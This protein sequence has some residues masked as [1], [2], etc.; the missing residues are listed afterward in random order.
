MTIIQTPAL[1]E[2]FE[3]VTSLLSKLLQINFTSGQR[4]GRSQLE[5]SVSSVIGMN[6]QGLIDMSELELMKLEMLTQRLATLEEHDKSLFSK[7]VRSLRTHRFDEYISTLCEVNTSC[8]LIKAKASFTKTEAPDFRIERRGSPIYLECTSVHMS[9][10]TSKDLKYKIES[11][12]REKEQK[13][14]CNKHTAL[15][16]DITNVMHHSQA[17]NWAIS[18]RELKVHFNHIV[19]DCGFGS[20]LMCSYVASLDAPIS[21]LDWCYVRFE[22]KNSARKLVRFLD[23]HF[24]RGDY[25]IRHFA[26]P[27][28]G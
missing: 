11:K 21:R 12:I 3:R 28:S 25:Q 2:R 20:V 7:F 1:A 13:P 19:K 10:P 16:I 26:I 23:R 24:P 18:P 27:Q 8:A 15:I 6:Q 9:N 17:S 4:Q 22:S 5:S 14:Y